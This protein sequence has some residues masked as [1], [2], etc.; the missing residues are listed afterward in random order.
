MDLIFAKAKLAVKMRATQPELTDVADINIRQGRHP[1][2]KDEVVVPLDIHI[3]HKVD[4]LLITGPNTGGKT[5]SLKLVGLFVLMAQSGLFIPAANDSTLP[6]FSKIFADIGDEQSI[7]QSLSTFSGHM[8]NIINII[9]QLDCKS[10]VLLDELCAGTDPSEGAALAI[11]ILLH[12]QERSAKVLVSTHYNELKIFALQQEN[13]LNACVE[14]D[15]ES[16]SPKY[17]IIMGIAGSSNAFYISSKLGL[18]EQII[19]V[20]QGY[21]NQEQARF[22]TALDNL[23]QEQMQLAQSNREMQVMREQIRVLQNDLARE[24]KKIQNNE[25]NILDK[26]REEADN[27]KRRA[28][29]EVEEVIESIKQL[30]KE[31]NQQVKHSKIKQAREAL[32]SEWVVNKPQNV[33]GIPLTMDN[34]VEGASVLVSTLGQVGKVISWTDKN[35]YVQIGSLKTYVKN[36]DCLLVKRSALEQ[37][38]PKERTLSNRTLMQLKNFRSELDIR[39]LNVEEATVELDKYIDDALIVNMP[40]VR[41]IHGKGTGLLK[42]GVLEYLANHRS[43][44]SFYDAPLSE[45]GSGAT[46]IC[47]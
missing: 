4:T 42:K 5:V 28:K 13:M 31:K 1:L 40:Q 29:R 22:S 45:G 36:S 21:V 17:R 6:L 47:F 2:I 23:E 27:I 38:A 43:V 9:N 18:S 25:K 39:G 44:K 35:V 11:S 20:A 8:S 14:F 30:E 19:K 33:A 41:I 26:A 12:M 37:P 34:I 15:K 3:P 46:I 32:S 10:L 24:R 7:E 16:L